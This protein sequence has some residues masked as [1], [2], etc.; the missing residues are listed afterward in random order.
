MADRRR[1]GSTDRVSLNCEID[2]NVKLALIDIA[3][4]FGLGWAVEKLVKDHQLSSFKSTPTLQ[5]VDSISKGG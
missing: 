1:K 2:V 4:E 3:G 5:V